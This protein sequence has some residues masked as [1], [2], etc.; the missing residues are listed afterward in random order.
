DV[1]SPLSRLGEARSR[2]ASCRAA[3]HGER[4]HGLSPG[5]AGRS[6]ATAGVPDRPRTGPRRGTSFSPGASACAFN[7][8]M[9]DRSSSDECSPYLRMRAALL[10]PSSSRLIQST[11]CDE[12]GR[13][14]AAQNATGE[15]QEHQARVVVKSA[16]RTPFEMFQPEV[17]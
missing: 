13:R 5:L 9:P 15:R 8:L 14:V 11:D 10:S 7:E 12:P 1:S 6:V 16:P 17:L 3:G 2:C 4:F